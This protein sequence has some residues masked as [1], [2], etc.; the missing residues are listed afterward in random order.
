MKLPKTGQVTI[1]E[2]A[3]EAGVSTQTVSRVV[4]NRQEI[5]PETRQRIQEIIK[6]MGYHPNAIA[7]SLSQRRT[8][9]L[10][11]AAS[12]IEYYGPSRQLLGI[13]QASNKLGYS[14]I[15][16]LIHR[17]EDGNV[18][19]VFHNLISRQ[20]EGII[21][22]VPQIGDNHSWL[23][24]EAQQLATPV[25]FIDM[26]PYPQF[27]IITMDNYTGGRLAT[28]HLL[29]QGYRKIGLITGP[30]NWWSAQER[31][32]GW[33][34]ALVAAGCPCE[35]RQMV[36]GDW[37]A[38]SGERGF[39]KLLDIFPEMEAVFVSNDQ[40]AFGVYQA[41]NQMGKCIPEDLAVVGF[42]DIPESGYFC[43]RLT[44]VRQDLYELGNVAVE[45]FIAVHE[46]EQRGEPASSSKN[47]VLQPQLI[48]RQSSIVDN[49]ER[50]RFEVDK[51]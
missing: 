11:V 18:E 40:M 15:L 44:T 49:Q 12:G 28:E 24:K 8:H 4:N 23:R 1:A 41:A 10:G 13:E 47:L 35:E 9:T 19:K 50:R 7:R 46:N 39:K 27:N 30:Q 26:Q 33:R 3:R 21:W 16:N 34:E 38:G 25:I 31:M 32:R 5:S 51:S 42:D 48:I 14:I 17:P 22:L 36:E 20:V 6:R 43:P 45:T 2:V 29:A 37:T